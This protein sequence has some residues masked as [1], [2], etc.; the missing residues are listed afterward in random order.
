MYSPTL[1]SP[2]RDTGSQLSGWEHPVEKPAETPSRLRALVRPWLAVLCAAALGVSVGVVIGVGLAREITLD[3]DGKLTTHRS[4]AADVRGALKA[5]GVPYE[6]GD[7]VSPPPS[8][9]IGDD[10]TIVVRHAR[11][12]TLN[13]D[14]TSS[15][16]LTTALNVQD[17]LLELKMNPNKLQLSTTRLRQ[18]PVEGFELDARSQRKV[19]IVAGSMRIETTTI[20]RTVEEVLKESN[21]ELGEGDKVSPGLSTFPPEDTVIRVTPG[22]PPH[23]IPISADVAALN[24]DALARCVSGNDA[25]SA[26]GGLYG[27][28]LKMWRAVGGEKRPVDWPE[29]E[30]TYRAQLLYQRLAGDWKRAWPD[31]G[32]RL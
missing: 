18:I 22:L 2:A 17:A 32:D 12:L 15:T 8:A 1:E 10:M 7:M 27:F 4:F 16:H 5:A 25:K 19:T 9:E 13:L 23:T 31:C 29:A 24:W 6:T 21:I 14:G 3:V 26:P 28:G 20:G 30:Q 11:P